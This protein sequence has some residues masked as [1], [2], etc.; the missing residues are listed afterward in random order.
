MMKNRLIILILLFSYGL[1]SEACLKCDTHK[2]KDKK[3]EI[4]KEEEDKKEV[5]S[6]IEQIKIRNLINL[7]NKS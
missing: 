1:Y 3:E 4:K 6:G 2:K 7:F 5:K